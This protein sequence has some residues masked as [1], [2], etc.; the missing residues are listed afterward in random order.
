LQ[1]DHIFTAAVQLPADR[2]TTA[3]QVT[4]F[5]QPLLARVKALPGVVHAA[6][7][8]TGAL[9]GGA[10]RLR[11]VLVGIAIGL[12]MSAL[13]GRAIGSQLVGVAAYDP[14]TLAAAAVLLAV[15]AA[16][17]S[18]IPARRAARVDPMVALRYE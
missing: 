6:A 5:L 3:E 16:T 12:A 13:L 15:T 14:P 1:A 18:W 2:Y 7:P 8:T 11:P 17:A 10:E 4:A 9:D